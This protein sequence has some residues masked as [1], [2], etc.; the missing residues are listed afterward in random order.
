[1]F[2]FFPISETKELISFPLSLEI[3]KFMKP[4]IIFADVSSLSFMRDSSYFFNSPIVRKVNR[5]NTRVIII[6]MARNCF[7]NNL[8]SFTLLPAYIQSP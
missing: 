1:M 3:G 4:L 6:K 2:I 8:R 5:E 7:Q